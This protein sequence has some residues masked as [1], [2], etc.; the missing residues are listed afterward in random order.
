MAGALLLSGFTQAQTKNPAAKSFQAADLFQV[1]NVWNVHL[2][3]TE[4][5]WKAMEPKGGQGGF[6]GGPGGGPMRGPGGPGGF[7]GPGGP[8]FGLA[9]LVAP[10]FLKADQNQDGKLS[11]AEFS[12]LAET[13]FAKWDKDQSGKLNAEQLRAGVGSIVTLPGFGPP[14]RGGPGGPGGRGPGLNLQGAEGKRNGLSAAMG[15]EF[16]YVHGDLEFEGVNFTNVAIRYKGNGTFMQSR[17]ALKRS[18]KVDLNEFVK[19]QHLAGVSKLNFHNNVTDPGW[20]N[21]VMSHQLFRDAG[22]PAPRTAYARVLLTVPGMYD[23]KLMGLYSVVENIDKSFVEE[24]FESKKGALFK[25]VTPQLFADLGGD[26]SNYKQTYDPKTEVSKAQTSRIIDLARLVT[27][28]GDDEF[29]SRIGE[30]LDLD[31]FARFMAV[32]VWLSTMDSILG[33]GQNYYVYLHPK[34]RKFQFMPWDLDHSFGQFG[35]MGSQEMRENL[36][37][38][39]PWM[40]EN[41]FLERVFRV[42]SFKKLYLARMNEFSKT[43]FKPERFHQQVDQIAKSIRPAVLEESEEKLARF[44][45]VVAGETITP[46][47]FGGFGGNRGDGPRSPGPGPGPGGFGLPSKPIK[48]FVT[49]RAD[50]VAAQLAGKSEG[51][52]VGGTPFGGPR[53][54]GG[55]PPGDFGPGQMLGNV[56]MTALDTK[57][58]GVVTREE[59]TQCFAKWF[60]DW[61]TDKTGTLTEEQLRAGINKD[62]TPS[63]G[64]GG[65]FGPG[66]P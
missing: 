49:A 41:R 21:E 64:G 45:K 48:G 12:T 28:A 61:N 22:V 2:R 30:Y 26:W 43:I 27:K 56:F 33:P 7:G 50:A 6:F 58:D 13:W 54:P 31:E 3:M 25:P 24:R 59:F 36:S 51:Q 9:M 57:K 66:R 10:A 39:R 52:N 20:M 23:K 17:G 42:E 44:D 60:E 63:R 5:Q 55:G 65:G 29:A 18:F 38:H 62:L 1:T 8:G 35:M 47:G 40:G 15:V 53:G 37:I 14:G 19:G 11:R 4:E 16:D 46:A 32:T 34:T